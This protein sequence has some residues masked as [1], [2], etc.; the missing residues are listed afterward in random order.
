MIKVVLN[1]SNDLTLNFI[2]MYFGTL[3]HY[4]LSFS[5]FMCY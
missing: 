2:L 5:E 3:K 4:Y 1:L